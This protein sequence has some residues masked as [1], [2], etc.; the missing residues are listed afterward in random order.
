[1]KDN[2]VLAFKWDAEGAGRKEELV[3]ELMG[4]DL[5]GAEEEGGWDVVLPSFV[6]DFGGVEEG[7]VGVRKE[8]RG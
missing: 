6:D 5:G 8:F 1:V 4:E 3:D 2:A 7:D